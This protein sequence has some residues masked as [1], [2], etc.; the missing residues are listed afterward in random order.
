M[1]LSLQ[2]CARV[3]GALG[4]LASWAWAGPATPVLAIEQGSIQGVIRDGMQVFYNL[5]FAKAP[6]GELR[7]RAPQPADSWEGVRSAQEMG[8]ACAQEQ[9]P[10]WDR[11]PKGTSEDCLYLNVFVPDK[12][13]ATP[14]PVMVW[15]HGG[16]FRWGSAMD[17]AFDGQMLTREGVI[18]VTINYRL[19]R[20][21]RF[22]HPALSALQADEPLGN[23]ALM[24]QVA[25]LEWV[26]KN[27]SSFGGDPSNVTIFGCS[28]GGVSVDFLMTS[29]KSKGLFSRAIAQSGSIVP[30]GERR[31]AKAA[32]M[33]PSLEE[34]GLK[35]A[36]YFGL[37]DA[38]VNS[39]LQADGSTHDAS[40]L[41]EKLRGLTT[42]QVLSYPQKDFSMQPIVDG[43]LIADDPARVFARGEQ[44]R[45]PLMSGA[46]TYE[47]SLIRPYNLPLN[48]V[49]GKIDLASA[50]Q[51]YGLNESA[52]LKD[53]FFGDSLFLS[54]AYFLTAQMTRA[55][56]PGYLYE[57]AYIN[58]DQRDSNPGAYHCSETSR[59]FGTEWRGEQ[60]KAQDIRMGDALRGYW[61][62]FAKTGNPNSDAAPGFWPANRFDQPYLLRLDLTSQSVANPYPERMQ[63]H[64]QRHPN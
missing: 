59:V 20:F 64:L 37:N 9:T 52:K 46:A 55:G 38:I 30:E 50:Q 40:A 26:Q 54:T 4:L 49:L 60:A 36:T 28:A 25:A 23:Y 12:V 18:L 7:W 17:P 47:A 19:D 43:S 45:V 63:L 21:G 1:A 62:R 33:F 29:Q 24:D 57:Y 13:S 48:L 3:C 56:Q 8:A 6:I 44:M 14:L 5:P 31:L 16:S 58:E 11:F 2:R 32:G 22:A 34:D 61:T 10:G 27:I 53:V 15:I 41:V 35:F 39:H 42:E 51:A